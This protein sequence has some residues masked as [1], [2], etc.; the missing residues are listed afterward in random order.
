MSTVDPGV[1]RT[2][3]RVREGHRLDAGCLLMRFY[4]YMVNIGSVTMLTLSGYSFLVAGLVSSAIA[5]SIFLLAPRVSKLIDTYGQ[6]RVVPVAVGVTLAGLAAML[7]IVSFHGPEWALFVAAVPMG[8][9]PN[10]P[11]LARTR[12]TYLVRAGKLGDR[13]PDLRTVFSYE[14]VID[15][16]GFM[17]SPSI[18]IALASTVAPTAGMVMGGVAYAVGTALLLSSRGTEPVP[19]WDSQRAGSEQDG[20]FAHRKSVFRT[21]AVVRV[22]F[23]LM[24]FLGAF[25]GVYDTA[26][27][28]FTEEAGDPMIASI[29]LMAGSFLSMIAGFVF[30][31]LKLGAPIHRQL[32]VSG[33]LIGAAFG[34]MILI[35]SVPSLV[36][37]SIVASAFYAPFI[38]IAN[39][40]CERA[41]SGDQLTEAITWLNA[42][43]TCGMAIGPSLCGAIVDSAGTVYGFDFG[44]AC[45]LA[46]PVTVF[47]CYRVL[48]RGLAHADEPRIAHD[49]AQ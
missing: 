26:T 47:L 37:V 35:D 15:D 22:L 16:I 38:I 32:S 9:S 6:V 49:S 17:F 2:I 34:A 33:I 8:C 27:V 30:G 12:W 13:A 7:A 1:Y 31:M 18:S 46:I 21:S 24:L 29:C 10:P 25:Y 5:L 36:A 19:G 20:A 23:V 45:A 11:A 3:L 44:G 14:G 28:A 4:P 42:G 48:K 43:V 40:V 39:T 41:V